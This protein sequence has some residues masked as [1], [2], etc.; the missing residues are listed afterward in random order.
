MTRDSFSI[1][2]AGPGAGPLVGDTTCTTDWLTI[3]CAT[4]STAGS[5]KQAAGSTPDTCIGE[6]S[7]SQLAY[8]LLST[9]LY[10]T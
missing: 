7:A 4:T 2:G 9:N 5:S 6:H 3:P 8:L 1:S 10:F